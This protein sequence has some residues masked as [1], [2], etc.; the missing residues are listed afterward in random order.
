VILLGNRQVDQIVDQAG[1][2]LL[3][4]QR[5]LEDSQ[6]RRPLGGHGS[7]RLQ[8]HAPSPLDNEVEELHGVAQFFVGLQAHPVGKARQILVLEVGRHG[9][10]DIGRMQLGVDLLVHRTLHFLA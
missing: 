5:V 6:R 2:L 7:D 3:V 8:Q 1:D 9:Q 10:I 4:R